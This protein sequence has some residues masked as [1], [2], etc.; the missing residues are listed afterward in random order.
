MAFVQPMIEPETGGG[1]AQTAAAPV[2][3]PC[4]PPPPPPEFWAL[5]RPG[6]GS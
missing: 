3:A 6:R 1:P 2:A 4:N 5:D